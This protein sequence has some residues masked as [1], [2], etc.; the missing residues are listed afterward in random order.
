MNDNKLF[1]FEVSVDLEANAVYYKFSNEKIAR[2]E[3][4]K[5][6]NLSLIFDYDS[7]GKIVG[8]EV[9]NLKEFLKVFALYS[10]LFPLKME[11]GREHM[12]EY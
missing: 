11:V 3:E 1:Q 7:E 4:K 2:S 6:N 9:L 8:I 10:S 5:S 12:Q